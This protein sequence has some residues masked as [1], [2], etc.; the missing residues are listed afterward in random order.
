[1]TTPPAAPVQEPVAQCTVDVSGAAAPSCEPLN[2]H[3]TAAQPAT[4]VLRLS[5][6]GIWANPDIP[7]DDAAKLVLEAIDDN[8]KILVQK[9]VL[10][11]REACAKVCFGFEGADPLGV[12]LDCAA[13]IRARSCPP[14]ND[15]CDQGR[16]CP[17]RSDK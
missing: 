11:E 9:A 14:C 8:I 1:M 2:W 15:D 7:A 4:E 6:D 12:S 3:K 5:K 16:N 17:A 10:A 13:A